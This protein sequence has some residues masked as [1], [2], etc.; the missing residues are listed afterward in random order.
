M[1][2]Q[3]RIQRAVLIN[4]K[5]MF[6][7]PFE[8]DPGMTVLEGANGTGKTTIMIAVY[9]C[10]MP[11][12]NFLNFQNVTGASARRNEDKGLYG[13]IGQDEKNRDEPIFTILD[14][15]TS[16]GVRHLVGVQ[17]GKKTYPQVALKHF[18]I[19]NLSLDAEIDKL[20]IRFDVDANL[21][22]VPELRE[23][24]DACKEHGGELVTFRHA[25]D[26]FQFLFDNDISPIRLIENE[27]RKKYNQLLH[28][29]LYGGLSRSLQTSLR[30]Y[31][32]PEN[33]K[34][35]QGIH[36]MEQNLKTCRRTRSAIQRYQSVREIIRKVYETGLN[37]YSS[38]FFA[39]RLES[40]QKVS[41]TLQAR[42]DKKLLLE[43]QRL[44]ADN[45]KLIR[46]KET[47]EESALTGKDTELD[48]AK[49]RLNRCLNA[50][51]ITEE[52]HRKETDF[53]QQQE[54]EQKAKEAYEKLK[55]EEKELHS[56]ERNFSQQQ[57]ELAK[58][59]SDAGKAWQELSRQVGLYQQAQK[60]LEEARGLVGDDKLNPE[61]VAEYITRTESAFEQARD[62]HQKAHFNLN[63]AML[64]HEH[65]SHY[66]KILSQVTGKEDLNPREAGDL[67]EITVKE[68]FELE[69]RI[70]EADKLP[71]KIGQL[72]AS[73]QNRER[74]LNALRTSD[75]VSIQSSKEYEVHRD[76]LLADLK[77]LNSKQK[78]VQVAIE[79][80]TS[81]LR[82]LKES[83]LSLE[84]QLGD[85]E[86]FQKIKKELEDKTAISIS[87]TVELANLQSSL[88]D[89]LQKLNLDKYEQKAKQKQI[90][91]HYNTLINDGAAVPGLKN[92]VEQGYGTLLADKY[93]EIPYD[94]AANLESRLGPMTNALVVKNIH[95]TANE[96]VSSFDRPDNVWLVEESLK[97][98]LPEAIELT[99]SILVKHGDAWRLSRLPEKPVLGKEARAHQIEELGNAIKKISA[100]LEDNDLNVKR[101][102][103]NQSLLNKLSLMDSFLQSSSPLEQ[104]KTQK[105]QQVELEESLKLGERDRK[106]TLKQI[107]LLEEQEDVLRQFYPLRELL[108]QNDL[109]GHYQNLQSEW[110]EAQE[111]EARNKDKFPFLAQLNQGL[112]ILK[113][114]LEEKLE[115]LQ[116]TESNARNILDNLR[117]SLEVLGR[118]NEAKDSFKF[119]DKV[120]LLDREKSINKHTESQLDEVEKQLTKLKQTIEQNTN[121]IA[122]TSE[123]FHKEEARLNTLKGQLELLKENLDQSG[124]P[125]GEEDLE[126]AKK[127]FS[128]LETEKK[129]MVS[130]LGRTRERRYQLE[131]EISQ[132][133][134]NLA[135][136]KNKF[137]SRCSASRPIT[138]KWSVFH[139]Q[140]RT[141][142][143]YEELMSEYS[144]TIRKSGKRSEVYWRQVSALR[145]TLVSTLEKIHDAK[146][147]LESIR[148]M[149][150]MAG[151]DVDQADISLKIWRKI[152]QYITQVIPI[153]LQTSDPE[154]A[155]QAIGHKLESLEQNLEQQEQS[156]RIHVQSIPSHLNAEIR[157]QKSRI[158]K[159][160]EKLEKV[161]FGFLDTI[162]I[163]IETHPKLKHF[164]DILPQQLDIF[165]DANEEDV[166]I[167]SLMADLYEKEGA[168]KVRGDLLMDYRHYVRLS[169]EVKR[170]GN[171]NFEKVTSTNLSTGESI[172]VGIAILI[173]VLMSWED[174]SYITKD[175]DKRGSLRFLLLDESSRLDQQA[176]YT[177]TDFCESLGLQLLIA[178]PSV[179]RTLRGTTHHLTRGHF[180]GREEVIVRGRRIISEN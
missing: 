33:D 30:D 108:N 146:A 63:E 84:K 40:E 37:M 54:I 81:E 128:T 86:R 4:W 92:L 114:P 3:T 85:W 71:D 90:Q 29:S 26:Y 22:E 98:K 76:S 121:G 180:D 118:L 91:K 153:D 21:Q 8:I 28:T 155:Q 39:A 175:S 66:L 43:Q 160:N 102:K 44:C 25:K 41:K 13:R 16:R 148:E 78:E 133:S 38:A 57:M 72:K 137:K 64:K 93:E 166:S 110:E 6:Y 20:L 124:A 80:E 136:A 140:A 149:T 48:I 104:I 169:I 61:E 49:E 17:L 77:N 58:Q 56:E 103:D 163:H 70:K 15:L 165:A 177:L 31:L 127:H 134:D 87:N 34:L 1:S 161:R 19:S 113:N 27:E 5:G 158:R 96:L 59:L 131:A 139:R 52:Y 138:K 112:E 105:L 132:V 179:E 144:S 24:G 2:N 60:L 97:E 141:G 125:G 130:E 12:L 11:D 10:L 79:S 14:I 123:S 75:L 173:M 170:E 122:A 178:A 36:E 46:Q 94:W 9:T 83:L 89:Q 62:N 135:K 174:Q 106:R 176:L 65:Y 172:G 53:L 18:A 99:D 82:R 151:D 156:L 7:Q 73:V 120:T 47:Q 116:T 101:V 50:H 35:V 145:V 117:R 42:H 115:E 109:D 142:R 88:E 171:Q 32:L 150:E 154:K 164:L 107:Q 157:K 45:I 129:E 119:E 159:L 168:G 67:A 55:A 69:N 51:K 143:K 23:I 167:E 100:S 68:L 152:Q 162:R 111:L 126:E 147:V 74:L 95:K